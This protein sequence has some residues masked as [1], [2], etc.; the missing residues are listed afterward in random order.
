MGKKYKNGQDPVFE[1]KVIVTMLAQGDEKEAAAY[2]GNMD[3]ASMMHAIDDGDMIGSFQVSSVLELA[4][5]EVVPA[6]EAVGNDGAFFD[7]E[8]E[9]FPRLK[10]EDPDAR[11]LRTQIDQG[12]SSESLSLQQRRFISRMG[13]SETFARWLEGEAEVEN[14][15]VAD[16]FEP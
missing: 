4:E 10:T 15:M 13:L 8:D 1:T 2:F 5:H 9:P 6:L 11:I 14:S 7:A 16:D 12:W 3:M